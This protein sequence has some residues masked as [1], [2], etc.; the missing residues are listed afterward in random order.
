MTRKVHCISDGAQWH[1]HHVPRLP[2]HPR[3]LH[4]KALC[5]AVVPIPRGL[6]VREPTCPQCRAEVA[7]LPEWQVRVH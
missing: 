3:A 5:G 1:S 4:V 7:R 6:D 2:A